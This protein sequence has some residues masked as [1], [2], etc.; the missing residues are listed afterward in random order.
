MLSNWE[1]QA[2]KTKDLLIGGT[3][4]CFLC[5][6]SALWYSMQSFQWLCLIFFLSNLPLSQGYEALHGIPSLKKKPQDHCITLCMTAFFSS[7]LALPTS[8]FHVP[9]FFP[10]ATPC[11]ERTFQN[12]SVTYNLTHPLFPFKHS[13]SASACSLHCWNTVIKGDCLSL[14]FNGWLCPGRQSGRCGRYLCSTER[15]AHMHS[16]LLIL[17]TV[18][19]KNHCT[20][21]WQFHEYTQLMV[22]LLFLQP[23]EWRLPTIALATV[24]FHCWILE[25]QK[26]RSRLQT[27][28]SPTSSPILWDLHSVCKHSS[29][30]TENEE[31]KEK[32]LLVFH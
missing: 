10:I 20:P 16:F 6:P 23:V 24:T 9:P 18:I 25:L 12:S 17:I 30:V 28:M 14:S 11:L 26:S 5:L 22:G 3:R 13:S 15:Q 8:C 7:Q 29:E 1:W 32:E 4:Q 19:K 21:Q 27:F 2:K 31:K